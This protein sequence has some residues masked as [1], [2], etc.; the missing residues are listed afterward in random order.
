MK[1]INCFGDSLTFGARDQYGLSYPSY[2]QHILDR[3]KFKLD[4]KNIIIKNSGING[5]TSSDLLRRL[6]NE[7]FFNNDNFLLIILIGSND[8]AKKIPNNIYEN[9]LNSIIKL[10]KNFYENVLICEIPF[11]NGIGLPTYHNKSNNYI[12]SYNSI[13]SKISKIYNI[14]KI[15]FD[16]NLSKYIIDTVHYNNKGYQ[17]IA[18]NIF[19]FI[20]SKYI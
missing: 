18:K 9:N 3:K 4:N 10:S 7:F 15:K 2:L 11:M 6:S 1:I 17:L 13:I 8:A 12:K 14:D 19:E 16:Q 5:N 20:K